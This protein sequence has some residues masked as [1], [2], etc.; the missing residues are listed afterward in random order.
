MARQQQAVAGYIYMKPWI[1]D[2]GTNT[3]PS[4]LAM[5]DLHLHS[6]ST[7]RYWFILL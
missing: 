3:E 7:V 1:S 4:F 6:D 2:L 5:P